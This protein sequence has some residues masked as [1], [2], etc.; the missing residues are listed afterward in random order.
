MEIITLKI[1][2]CNPRPFAVCF[3]LY[4]VKTE[5]LMRILYAFRE[6]KIYKKKMFKRGGGS[7]RRAEGL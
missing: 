6:K 3:N 2:N 1:K 5:H 4:Y 7:A